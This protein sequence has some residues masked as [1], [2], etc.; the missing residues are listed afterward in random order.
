MTARSDAEAPDMATADVA[1]SSHAPPPDPDGSE[2]PRPEGDVSGGT[3][4]GEDGS[5]HPPLYD[6][7][8]PRRLS[9]ASKRL[10]GV[11]YADLADALEGWL[12]SRLRARVELEVESTREARFTD[13]IRELPDPC[14]AYVIAVGGSAPNG[15]IEVG[16]ELSFF[17]V[18]RTL[19]GTGATS[20]AER[21]LTLLERI[22]V[23]Q[24][25]DRV[26]LLLEGAWR[27][28]TQL[29]V[30]V[31]GFE[32]SPEMIRVANRD[33]AMLSAR[34]RAAGEDWSSFL[35]LSL[36]AEILT[37]AAERQ[38]ASTA[39]PEALAVVDRGRLEAALRSARLPVSVR[40]PRFPVPMRAIARLGV[41]SIL[42]SNLPLDTHVEVFVSGKLRHT[43]TVGRQGANLAVRVRDEARALE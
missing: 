11:T 37:E 41:G 32:A 4:P 14:V 7:R 25:I 18:E 5:E 24:V 26:G 28:T 38:I 29:P 6:F 13:L 12:A 2:Q 27:D 19:G 16:P 10:L 15:L 22:L 3:A 43:G 31:E 21:A 33:D 9:R 8:Q 34:F 1:E 35:Q 39:P 23:R 40:L 20:V 36:P 42:P 17:I 30:A